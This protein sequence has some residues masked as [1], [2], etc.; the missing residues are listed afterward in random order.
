MKWLNISY[1]NE[2]TTIAAAAVM[3]INIDSNYMHTTRKNS[4]P[5]QLEGSNQNLRLWKS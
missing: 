4:R 3:S 1:W 5:N 2:D